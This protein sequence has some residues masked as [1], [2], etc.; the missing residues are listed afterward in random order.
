M[1]YSLKLL[2]VCMFFFYGFSYLDILN[3]ISYKLKLVFV[4]LIFL[5]FILGV[6]KN[7]LNKRL[8]LRPGIW[9]FLCVFN[10]LGLMSSLFSDYLIESLFT[11]IGLNMYFYIFYSLSNKLIRDQREFIW[12]NNVVIITS[13]INCLIGLFGNFGILVQQYHSLYVGRTRIF[14]LFEHPNYLGAI[15]FVS[16]VA[17]FIN[18]NM[19]NKSKKIRY[20]VMI[21]FFIICMILSDSRGGLY[22]LFIFLG[23]YYLGILIIKVQNK[24]LKLFIQ[25]FSVVSLFTIT[26]LY[27]NII[28]LSSGTID[29]WTS[30]RIGN[31]AY[32]FE[33]K[34]ASKITWLLFGQGLSS[35]SGG[36]L[37]NIG[38]NTDNG[39]L[40]WIYQTGILGLIVVLWLLLYMGF[41]ILNSRLTIRKVVLFGVFMSF[42]IYN[43]VENLLMNMGMIISLYSWLVLFIL[44]HD[45]NNI[46]WFNK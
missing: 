34:I 24:Y 13:F 21:I 37:L 2:I 33:E 14:G 11:L 18:L 28:N 6:V 29:N 43:F 35:G 4:V 15:A 1:K 22:S 32:I 16:L 19:V 41:K 12:L 9:V 40:V 38:I 17:C 26:I 5:H 23:I 36:S 30:G 44:V 7:G 39:F 31:W 8:F 46:R 10:I 25:T 20:Y 3:E 42:V 27:L 45:E